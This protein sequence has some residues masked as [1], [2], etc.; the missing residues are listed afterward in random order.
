[1]S[2]VTFEETITTPVALKPNRALPKRALMVAGAVIVLA[3][4]GALVDRHAGFE[5]QYRRRLS[6]GRLHHRCAEGS[7]PRR[8]RCWCATIRPCAP[9]SR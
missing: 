2:S 5:R 9:V 3:A 4:V 6:E 7:R 8:T 1:M